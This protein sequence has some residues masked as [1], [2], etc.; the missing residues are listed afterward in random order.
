MASFQIS[1]LKTT[2]VLDGSS[3]IPATITQNATFY[4]NGNPVSEATTV[5]RQLSVQNLRTWFDSGIYKQIRS[6]ASVKVTPENFTSTGVIQFHAP[7]L[8]GIYAGASDP[9]GW[10]VC[11]G[12]SLSTTTYADLFGVIGYSYGGSGTSFNIPNFTGRAVF[13]LDGMGVSQANRITS[14]NSN[15]VGGTTGQ[16]ESTLTEEQTPVVSHTHAVS[17]S[18]GVYSGP[19]RYGNNSGRYTGRPR[20]SFNTSGGGCSTS[21]SLSIDTS[22]GSSSPSVEAHPNLPPFMLFNWIIKY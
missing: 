15:V 17:G 14:A 19:R 18:F 1:D 6:G 4:N 5:T 8:V 10:F 9:S 22:S 7:G 21:L 2:E 12:R 20:R 13:G 3:F 16:K 11:N